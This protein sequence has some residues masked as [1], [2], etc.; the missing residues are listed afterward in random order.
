MIVLANTFL[1]SLT[2]TKRLIFGVIAM[3]SISLTTV[4]M[5]KTMLRNRECEFKQKTANF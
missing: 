5:S 1:S 2:S 3:M 4:M